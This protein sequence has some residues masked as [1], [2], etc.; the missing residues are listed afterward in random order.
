MD[1]IPPSGSPLFAQDGATALEAHL[2]AG[3]WKYD[4]LS[5]L[6]DA[7]QDMVRDGHV[8]ITGSRNG[9]VVQSAN[10]EGF[11][12]AYARVPQADDPTRAARC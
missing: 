10:L 4:T 12:K 6:T 7:I 5:L 11:C 9:R 8:K 1:A 3:H 2:H